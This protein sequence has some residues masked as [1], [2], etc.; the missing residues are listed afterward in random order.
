MSLL[1]IDTS[2]EKSQ[3][4]LAQDV[5]TFEVKKLPS[6]FKSSHLLVSTIESFCQDFDKIAI[7]SGPGSYTGIRVA[8][9]VAKGLAFPKKLP[10]IELCSL[11]GFIPPMPGRYLSLIDAR[12]A[13]AYILLQELKEGKITQLG[14]PELVTLEELPMHLF[15][16]K[17]VVGPNLTRFDLLSCHETYA[18]PVQLVKFALAKI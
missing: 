16:C 2:T 11:V 10:I 15:T 7:T 5:E 18:D 4:I 17:G 12:G 6:G 14:S 1:I 9:A 8:Q 3:V 13:G